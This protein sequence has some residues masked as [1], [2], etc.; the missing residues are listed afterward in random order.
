MKK[1]IIALIIS[2]LATGAWAENY[3]YLEQAKEINGSYVYRI[4]K[5]ELNQQR[6]A[7]KLFGTPCYY[8]SE[9]DAGLVYT[10]PR[11]DALKLNHHSVEGAW[12][13]GV[14]VAPFWVTY[15]IGGRYYIAGNDDGIPEGLEANNTLRLGIAWR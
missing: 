12:H 9:I 11:S 3:L 14:E 7:G 6:F 8:L 4:P 5:L 1:I 15:S 13:V 2:I 10:A